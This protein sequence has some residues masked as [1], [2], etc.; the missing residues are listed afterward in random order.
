LEDR[1]IKYKTYSIDMQKRGSIILGLSLGILIVVTIVIGLQ[2]YYS[3][4]TISPSKAEYDVEPYGNGFL[5]SANASKELD[6]TVNLEIVKFGTDSER[7][8]IDIPHTGEPV[9]VEPVSKIGDVQSLTIEYNGEQLYRE[10]ISESL[11]TQL[12]VSKVGDF[13][14]EPRE[15]LLIEVENFVNNTE[16]V[17]SYSWDTGSKIIE[18]KSFKETYEEDGTYS[19]SLIVEDYQGRTYRTKFNV[20]VGAGVE[21]DKT[22][23][24]PLN[25]ISVNFT[26]RENI[27]LT[28]SKITENT[29]RRVERYSWDFD[30]GV[31]SEGRSV[32]HQYNEPG[33]YNVSL[34]VLY[35]SGAKEVHKLTIF[36]S[37]NTTNGILVRENLGYEFTYEAKVEEEVSN[38][39]W[40]LGDGTTIE[41]KS[42][43]EHTYDEYGS[44]NVTLHVNKTY[45]RKEIFNTTVST[46]VLVEMSGMPYSIESVSGQHKEKLLPQN[47]I[48]D[49]NP[50]IQFREGIRYRITNI[51]RDISFE[52]KSGEV[53]LSQSEKG[54]YETDKK[55]NWKEVS[56]DTVE[57]TVTD[58][59]GKDLYTYKT[60]D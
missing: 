51:P 57:F 7:R 2:F 45:G 4:N 42:I 41:G 24:L 55:V 35:T 3:P 20:I 18:N 14:V 40:K 23:E 49:P 28:A 12:R 36:V 47:K 52:S 27:Y 17:K 30:N 43:L 29:N 10:F 13:R 5:I 53:L 33:I 59:L 22:L 54:I 60:A 38:Y 6:D 48:G 1:Y 58:Q 8:V 9:Y 11:T 16:V 19:S 26:V 31:R 39:L 50:S 37:E 56:E 21:E 15:E 25:N 44:Y 34:E 32:I 46:E